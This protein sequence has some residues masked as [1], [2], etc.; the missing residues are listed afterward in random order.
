MRNLLSVTSVL[1][2]L[3]LGCAPAGEAPAPDVDLGAERASLMQADQ[4]WYE[5]FS[6]SDSPPDTLV[7][8]VLD[9]VYLLAPDAPLARGKEAFRATF[10]MLEATPGFSLSWSPSAADVGSAGDFGFTIG[11]YE[12]KMDG[13]EGMPI[14]IG[15]KYMTAWKKQSDGTW[16]VAA[17][18]FNADGPPSPIEE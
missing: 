4:A 9:D 15:G 2:L 13:P 5:A 8:Q 3:A 18:M 17:D 11:A 12:M 14:R 10:A 1:L 7:T 16:K 6:T